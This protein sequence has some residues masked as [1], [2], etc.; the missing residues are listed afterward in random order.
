MFFV[1]FLVFRSCLLC[2]FFFGFGIFG[3][4]KEKG[5]CVF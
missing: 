2:L 4:V 5:C 1:L 3:F